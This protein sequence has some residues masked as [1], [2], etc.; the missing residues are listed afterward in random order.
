MELALYC[1]VYGFYEKEGDTIGRRGDY[2]TSV[3]VGSLFGEL[4]AWRFA[5]WMEEGENAGEG[6]GAPRELVEAG[7]HG[8]EL[9]RDI[10]RW[11]RNERAA[12]Y[13]RV[14]YWIVEPSPRRREWQARRLEEF[15][16]KVCWATGLEDLRS[17]VG[18]GIRGVIFSNELFDAMPVHRLR[19][20]AK[21]RRWYEWGVSLADGSRFSW[22]RLEQLPE[23]NLCP[24]APD[25]L[26]A[27]LPEGFTVEV[28]PAASAWWRQ[29]AGM[30]GHGRLLTLDYG[31]T[32]EEFFLPHR[33]AGTLRG[34]ARHR[35]TADVLADP[36][37]QDLTAHVDFSAL[38]EAGVASGLNTEDFSTQ[39]QFLTRIAACVWGDWGREQTRQF[40]TLIHP[41]HLG[42]FRVLV[43]A[44]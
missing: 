25:E 6:A 17:K 30:L 39:A 43:Q 34:Y 11:L 2:Y 1:P 26:L 13:E 21:E 24:S 4:L 42:R 18:R 9:A 33:S 38:Q 23:P 19:W 8:G 15:G 10:L 20:A 14:R 3:S 27:I 29:A 41:E 32:R 37:E 31:L 28:C 5:E 7:A 22:T 16:D 40:Q 12:V 35:V 36:G 44:T